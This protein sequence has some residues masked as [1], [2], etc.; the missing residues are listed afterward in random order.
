MSTALV[1]GGHGFAGTALRSVLAEHGWRAVSVGRSERSAPDYRRADVTDPDA[2][3][4]LLDDVRP[5]VIFHLAAMPPQR[6]DDLASIVDPLVAAATA[7]VAAL[8]RTG[9]RPR[10]VHAGSSAQYGALPEAE[11]PVTEDSRTL[12]VSPYGFAK[13]AA[14]ATLRAYAAAGAIDL[15]PVR[16]FNHIGPGEPAY[17]VAGAFAARVAAVAAG[18]ADH[19]AA[20]DL[21]AVRDFTDVRDI[22]RGYLAVATHGTA[23][24]VY[25]LC[26]GRPTRIGEVL[27]GLLFAAGLDRSVVRLG[28]E[29]GGI[30]YQVGSPARVT[31]ETGWRSG[32]PL[33]DSLIDL[34]KEQ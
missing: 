25:H 29:R 33:V 15:V 7:L 22:A 3:A 17:T 34:L 31:A 30:P 24:R 28:P 23:G 6:A 21:D 20:A 2:V 1:T 12:P 11:N 18:R 8:R 13:A 19:V 10:V 9:L 32:T 26:S 14:E 27:D 4:A 5:D 16:A